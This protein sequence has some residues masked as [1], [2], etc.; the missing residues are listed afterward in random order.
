[1][2]ITA[3]EKKVRKGVGK[4]NGGDSGWHSRKEARKEDFTKE[5]D[6][7]I[8]FLKEMGETFMKVAEENQR[9]N[10]QLQRLSVPEKGLVCVCVCGAGTS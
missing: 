2:D 9:E 3:K 7:W 6:T 8:H 1:M 5:D 10:K 4:N